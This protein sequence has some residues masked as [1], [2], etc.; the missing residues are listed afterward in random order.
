MILLSG[1]CRPVVRSGPN[2]Q[3]DVSGSSEVQQARQLLQADECGE[4]RRRLLHPVCP[5][6][7]DHHD[8]RLPPGNQEEALLQLWN[9]G[10]HC[11]AP[12]HSRHHQVSTLPRPPPPT[13]P[14]PQTPLPQPPSHNPPPQPPPPYTPTPHPP[15]PSC[16]FPTCSMPAVVVCILRSAVCWDHQLQAYRT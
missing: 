4:Q 3:Q 9:R 12:L 7:P 11:A 10:L 14:V 15:T 5:L 2:C 6:R 8:N 1:M 13:P 16:L